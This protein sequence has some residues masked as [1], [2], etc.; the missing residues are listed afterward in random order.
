MCGFPTRHAGS[1]MPNTR[2]VACGSKRRQALVDIGVQLLASQ[3]C[4]DWAGRS[5]REDVVRARRRQEKSKVLHSIDLSSNNDEINIADAPY[6]HPFNAANYHASPLRDENTPNE[7]IV[8][9]S[10]RK[11]QTN[12]GIRITTASRVRSCTHRKGNG[13][14][15]MTNRRMARWADF[16]SQK[17]CLFESHRPRPTLL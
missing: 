1:W 5:K 14:S 6:I 2:R 10:N 7:P 4:G 9:T 13:S 15:T 3:Q 8:T 17:A 16:L 12:H 11:R